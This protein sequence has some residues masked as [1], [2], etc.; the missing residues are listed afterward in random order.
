M[1]SQ[2]QSEHSR[3]KRKL[4]QGTYSIVESVL[5]SKPIEKKGES[6]CVLLGFRTT[7][8]NC[9]GTKDADNERNEEARTWRDWT[10][11]G[12]LYQN[13]VQE[14]NV[15]VE[16]VDFCES[17]VPDETAVFHYIVLLYLQ[18]SSSRGKVGV[19][20]CV[21]RFRVRNMSGYVT[22][23]SLV[24]LGRVGGERGLKDSL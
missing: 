11:I 23:Y 6:L 9:V 5:P 21:A 12:T 24:S 2:D 19:L 15:E 10:G 14:Q 22:V 18:V 3:K 17:Y 1:G 8:D 7:E 4:I 13:L 20:D 16:Q